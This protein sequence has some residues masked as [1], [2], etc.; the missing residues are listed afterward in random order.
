M[1]HIESKNDTLAEV[2]ALLDA[3]KLHYDTLGSRL[4]TGKHLGYFHVKEQ[5]G[6]PHLVYS[7]AKPHVE[8]FLGNDVKEILIADELDFDTAVHY[9]VQ[10]EQN[11]RIKLPLGDVISS[12]D[13]QSPD[14]DLGVV[15]PDFEKKIVAVPQRGVASGAPTS[16]TTPHPPGTTAASTTSAAVT[17]PKGKQTTGGAVSPSAQESVTDAIKDRFMKKAAAAKLDKK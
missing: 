7:E 11:K 14:P 6:R 9:V 12:V 4:A 13:L 15:K 5:E 3:V 16:S 8:V 17:T 1:P 10:N 2:Q